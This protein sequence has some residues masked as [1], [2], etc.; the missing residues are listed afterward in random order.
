MAIRPTPLSSIPFNK[1]TIMIPNEWYAI[2]EAR[3]LGRR[4]VGVTR[5]GQDLVLWRDAAGAPVVMHNRCP[6]R[7]AK[8][9]LGKVSQGCI[10]CPY[11][12]FLFDARGACRYIPA[13][14]GD[15]P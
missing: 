8:F 13:N 10:Q 12:G 15:R 14:G 9:D 5:L 7:G 6:H 1:G 2:F 4:P 3:D 11:H